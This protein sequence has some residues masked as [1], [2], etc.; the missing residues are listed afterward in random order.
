MKKTLVA[1]IALFLVAALGSPAEAAGKKFKVSIKV[2]QSAIY[3]GQTVTISGKVS[4]RA[5]GRKVT[6]QKRLSTSSKWTTE[7]RAK[8]RSNGTYSFTD[9]PTSLK[10]RHYRVYKPK[11][12]KRKS[13]YSKARKVVVK[14]PV[15]RPAAI[16][17][18]S[19][20]PTVIDAGQQIV[21]N[22]T[23]SSNLRGGRVQLQVKEGSTWSKLSG[24]KVRPD[25]RFT[26]TGNATRAGRGQQVRAYA[27]ATPHSRAAASAARSFTVYGW[28]YLE[29]LSEVEG[30]FYSG[31]TN[32]NGVTYGKSVYAYR[33]YD[34]TAQWDLARKCTRFRAIAGITDG[35]EAAVKRHA[36]VKADSLTRWSRTNATLGSSWAI[37]VD[38]TSALRLRLDVTEVANVGSF[39]FGDARIRCAF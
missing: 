29:D 25:G 8:I 19:T 31:S 1:L 6:I 7:G 38:L 4:P 11:Q 37:D 28:Y 17:I 22:G 21:L 13:G 3:S 12:G 24:A 2:S 33:Y 26:L 39:G 14:K 23:T 36:Y 34:D 15:Q 18:T 16:A 30:G 10:W 20:G 35:S 27:K 9:K 5:A 32:I